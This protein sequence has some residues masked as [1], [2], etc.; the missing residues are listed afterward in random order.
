M[1]SIPPNQIASPYS[2]LSLFDVPLFMLL[3]EYT[4]NTWHFL[5]ENVSCRMC[6][7]LHLIYAVQ[8][9]HLVSTDMP[10]PDTTFCHSNKMMW[11][12]DAH[13]IS[14]DHSSLLV[15]ERHILLLNPFHVCSYLNPQ[16]NK[17]SIS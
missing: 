9:L 15:S 2:Y 13:F 11:S 6:W 1:I 16:A 10:M 4:L 12:M 5:L 14:Q 17:K 3:H 8:A 7:R